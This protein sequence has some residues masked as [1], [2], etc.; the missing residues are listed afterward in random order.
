MLV[1]QFNL[2]SAGVGALLALALITR[3]EP[4]SWNWRFL[5]VLLL[6]SVATVSI[7]VLY[8]TGWI[9]NYP[10][11]IG[12]HTPMAFLVG[13]LFL[14]F[15]AFSIDPSRRIQLTDT[16]HLLPFLVYVWWLWPVYTAP[17]HIKISATLN[18]FFN[19]SPGYQQTQLKHMLA[20]LTHF[21]AYIAIAIF[22]INRAANR[23]VLPVI[24]WGAIGIWLVLAVRFV[25]DTFGNWT[26]AGTAM[27]VPSAIS[28]LL[29]LMG[30]ISMRQQNSR[31]PNG[32]RYARSAMNREQAVALGLELQK[33]VK[34][35]RLFLNS[36]FSLKE[37]AAQSGHTRHTVS[38]ALN[39]GCGLRF[40]EFINELRVAEARRRIITAS[41]RPNFSMLA[42]DVG[43]S[44]R[45]TFYTA[46]RRHLGLT[47]SELWQQQESV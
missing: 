8:E 26:T 25:L 5:G 17:E 9:E 29:L 36:E 13:P 42:L 11:L 44:S 16:L 1:A 47:P 22:L 31:H 20:L 28:I 2:I 35:Q 6:V 15:V 3:R 30:F 43:F 7:M 38:Q 19:D 27:V 40:S 46:F 45:T 39:D 24:V 37:L 34:Q 10:G 12:V 23:P 18:A 14:A 41:A 33:L 21:G 32:P 4:D